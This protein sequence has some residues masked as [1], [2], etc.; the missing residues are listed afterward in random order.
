MRTNKYKIHIKPEKSSGQS[1]PDLSNKGRK[2]HSDLL[3]QLIF[4]IKLITRYFRI[5]ENGQRRAGMQREGELWEGGE[6]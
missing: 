1:S 5:E 2:D 4:I 6:V 3:A